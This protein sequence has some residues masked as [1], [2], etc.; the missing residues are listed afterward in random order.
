M[1]LLFDQTKEIGFALSENSDQSEHLFSL[2]NIPSVHLVN[3]Q[4]PSKL[5]S[6]LQ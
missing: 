2:I 3:I 5:S 4:W 6:C 1:R